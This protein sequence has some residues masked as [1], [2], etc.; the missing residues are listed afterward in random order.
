MKIILSLVLFISVIF[1]GT[2]SVADMQ[3]YSQYKNML[4]NGGIQQTQT[5]KV[6]LQE[7]QNDVLLEKKDAEEE[8]V[9]DEKN[10]KEKEIDKN[11]FKYESQEVEL[12]RYGANFFKNK[13]KL[14]S[15]SIP[16]SN[17]YI[18]K[19]SDVL[20]VNTF[21]SK[22]TNS[23]EL[24]VDN[25]NNVFIQKIGIVKVGGLSF[26][27]VKLLIVKKIQKSFPN[28][29]VVVDIVKYSTIQV[30]LSGNVKVPGIYNLSPFATIKDA[31]IEANGLLEVGS[32]RDISII[33]D[34]RKVYTFDLYKLLLNPKNNSDFSL[35]NN[36]IVM[37]D[38]VHKSIRLYG[39]VKY[40]AIYELK[41]TE[42][43]K[44]LLKYSGGFSY[45]ATKNS[46]KLTRYN[47]DKLL[48]TYILSKEALLKMQPKDGDKLEVFNNYEI[49]EKPYILV[50]G[51]VV[52]DD[53]AKY[54]YFDGMKISQLFKMVTFRSEIY[55]TEDEEKEKKDD[56][57]VTKDVELNIEN[58][59][60]LLVDKTKIKLIRNSNNTKSTF[61]LSATDDFVLKPFDE[62]EFYNYFDTHPRMQI[63]ITG[64][65]Y[66]NGNYFINDDTTLKELL[67]LAGGMTEK[68]YRQEFE[69]VRYSIDKNE[70]VREIKKYDLQ[71]ALAENFKLQSHDEINIFTIPN[72]YD[73][74]TVTLK[75]EVKFPGTYSIRTGEKLSDVIQRAGGF[76]S[77]AFIEGAVFTRKSI[78][79]NEEKR[80]KEAMF[81][82]KQQITFV[83]A[84]AKEVGTEKKNSQ[85][86]SGVITMLE[87][88]MKEYK[89]LGRLIV[90]LDEN[91]QNFKSSPYNIRLEDKDVLAIPS[92][93]DIVSVYGE[94]MNP[95]SF[96]YSD[97]FSVNDYIEKAGGMTQRA[98][99]E[100]IYMVMANGEAKKVEL[101]ALFLSNAEVHSGATIVIPMQVNKVSN[102]LLWKEVSQIV[103]QL[104]ITAAS[105]STVGAL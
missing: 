58:R 98:D 77:E 31:L 29:K 74:K 95:N 86:L 59:E 53:M 17:D 89:A 71:K 21:G 90:Y 1:A 45:D 99:D 49:K 32:Y 9:L 26:A 56:E 67:S 41:D 101:N 42:T 105:L 82:L 88:Q 12:K 10:T 63:T 24:T 15:T 6:E 5:R 37:V 19:N 8:Q 7:V 80:M 14:E 100:S 75:G 47:N 23:Y 65:V 13:N 70:R 64:E 33:R 30:V 91:L 4:E 40:P 35:R 22:H 48:K 44:D 79:E 55:N 51:K 73:S 2:I 93:N 94:V 16:T 34:H 69:L 52:K 20:L 18:L 50:H 27:D 87:K 83:S 25:N 102:I 96:I 61:L 36:D 104:A 76:T 84:N 28:T 54:E 72:W 39:K 68:A 3:K 60:A 38:F 78:Q 97:E 103:Y 85:E 11:I 66:K 81:R 43:F 57:L 92:F 62:I 46:I